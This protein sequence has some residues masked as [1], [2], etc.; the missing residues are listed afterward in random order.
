KDGIPA[1]VAEDDDGGRGGRHGGSLVD[2]LK[3]ALRQRAAFENMQSN[4]INDFRIFQFNS[5]RN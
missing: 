5:A 1:R 4:P 3:R 2:E